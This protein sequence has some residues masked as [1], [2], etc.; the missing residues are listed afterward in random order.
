MAYYLVVDVGYK[1]YDRLDY[2][3]TTALVSMLF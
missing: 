2:L 3:V 1:S